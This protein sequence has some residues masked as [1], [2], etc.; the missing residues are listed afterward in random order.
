MLSGRRHREDKKEGRSN[1]HRTKVGK[2]PSRHPML[3]TKKQNDKNEC[4]GL[5]S[6]IDYGGR[7]LSR[8]RL[9][10]N[11]FGTLLLGFLAILMAL[12]HR[13]RRMHPPSSTSQC[14]FGTGCSKLTKAEAL[15]SS[16]FLVMW[17]KEAPASGGMQE[18]MASVMIEHHRHMFLCFLKQWIQLYN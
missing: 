8:T 6:P 3:T 18:V 2:A 1:V 7:I 10:R 13:L 9:Y 5:F 15:A 4:S 16:A 14:I 17:S 11:D 12:I